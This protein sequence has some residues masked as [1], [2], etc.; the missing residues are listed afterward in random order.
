MRYVLDAWA[1]LAWLQDE[2]PASGTIQTLLDKA[3]KKELILLICGINLGEVYY[4]YARKFGG[5]KGDLVLA[6]LRRSPLKI[7]TPIS[8]SSIQKAASLKACFP[9]S[10]SDG[11]AAATAMERKATL[12]TGDPDFQVLAKEIDIQWLKR[13]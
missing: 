11:F 13:S 2:S 3:E 1:V 10:Y 12:V 8:W 4:Q 9:I 5:A 6:T 7:I